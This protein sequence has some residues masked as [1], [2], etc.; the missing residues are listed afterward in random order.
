MAQIIVG[1]DIGTWSVKAAVVESTMRGFALVDFVE[2]V[3]PR[4][5]DGSATERDVAALVGVALRRHRDHDAVS[6]ALPGSRVLA[7]DISL[8]FAD[9][10][11]IRSV[12]AF[13]L[14]DQFPM[15]MG[16]LVYDYYRLDG[17]DD[18]TR[19]LCP[20]VE[21]AWLEGH[22]A[23]LAEAQ[24]D[25]R[26]V[27]V[28]NLAHAQLLR[29]MDVDEDETIAMVDLGHETTAITVVVGGRVRTMRTIARGGLQVTEALA[30][31]FDLDF[32]A[33]ERLK[34]EGVRLDD[35]PVHGVSEEEQ[36][37]RADAVRGAWTPILRDLRL[38]LHA[39]KQRWLTGPDQVILFGG[40][41]RMAGLDGLVS[42]A[43]GL[44]VKGAAIVRQPWTRLEMETRDQASLPTAVAL[45]IRAVDDTVADSVN[46]RQGD[47]AYE[48]D[49][50][51]LRDR[52]GWLAVV[53]FLLIALFFGRQMLAQQGLEDNHHALVDQLKGFSAKVLGQERDDFDFVLKRLDR[54]PAA[55][56]ASILPD[57]S[58]FRAFYEVTTA[59]L[60]VNELDPPKDEEE[61]SADEE[62][63]RDD[64]ETD[65]D[66]GGYQVELKQVQIDTKSAFIKGEANNIEAVEAFTGEL[67]TNPCFESVETNDT[68]RISFGNR[69]D[70]LRF[71]L[72][73]NL[74]CEAPKEDEPTD[75][76]AEPAPEEPG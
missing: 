40:S 57:I 69:Q 68:T 48:S 21:R 23:S 59:Q 54:P 16:E 75:E 6:T 72:K 44:P 29:H 42:A 27:T 17:E 66:D 36:A 76:E 45:A 34:H 14:E 73:V 19:M 24:A 74:G 26:I 47:L 22:L 52:A 18:E 63:N 56:A 51:V 70:W 55:E 1:L 64:E 38:T 8:P 32:A 13:Q 41:T 10:K 50:K 35:Q 4:T 33:A 46:F 7:R 49:F 39:H 12:L 2:H 60:K 15:T 9:D 31:R 67:K 25:P 28:A 61:I 20:A 43:L 37:E 53:T 62:T 58:A 11:R 65:E 3:I 71:Q 5:A 30:A